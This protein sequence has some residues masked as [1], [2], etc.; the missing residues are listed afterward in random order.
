VAKPLMKCKL[1]IAVSLCASATAGCAKQQAAAPAM[2]SVPVLT[3]KA[4]E[5]DVP[6]ELRA[7]GTVEAYSTVS[8]K[9]QVTG[10]VLSVHFQEGQEVRKGDLLFEIDKRPFEV[11]LLQAQSDAA[12]DHARAENSRLQ[13][14]RLQKLFEQGITPKE[15]YEAQRA[16]ADAQQA[17]VQ[18]DKAAIE[19]AKLNLQYCEI[20]SPIDGRTG[21][22]MVKPG[23]IAKA[24]DVPVLVVIN[25][26][27]PIYVNFSIPE[28]NLAEVKRYQAQGRMQVVATLA[29]EAPLAEK[30]SL[31][32]MDNAVDNTTGTI[33][34]KA[35]FANAQ[36]KL[37]PGQFV[38]SVLTLTTRPHAIVVP[39]QAVS[40]S[41][42]G[43]FVFVIK[44]D[45]TAEMRDIAPGATVGGET[46]VEKGLRAGETVVTDGQVRLFPGAHVTIKTGS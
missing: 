27:A 25:Q 2:P 34:L 46:I 17:A 15:Q 38:T 8:I 12:R 39:S 20:H 14:D 13:A 28:Q 33:H 6:V 43:S 32:F 23:N 29:G 36:R 10:L 37:W 1:I 7:I 18:S 16:D 21:A 11:A 31:A 22:V 26:V 9:A 35:L 44:S 41:Q 45:N 4:V 5:K 30:G 24:N 19:N 3:A 40:T 42:S